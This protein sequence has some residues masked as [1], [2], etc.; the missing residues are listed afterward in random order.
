MTAEPVADPDP[1]VEQRRP[2]RTWQES[3]LAVKTVL[4]G[5]FINR[6]GGFIQIFLVLYMTNHGFA[7][8]QAGA[9]LSG[10]GA[11]SIVGLL[12]GG[13]LSDRIGTRRTIIASMVGSAALI[14]VL[15]YVGDRGAMPSRFAPSPPASAC[16]ARRTGRRRRACSAS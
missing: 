4:I 7:A 13:W 5:V 11:G 1:P 12:A 9:A 10:Y 15:L 8:G 6:L 2:L 16:S 14:P 3:P